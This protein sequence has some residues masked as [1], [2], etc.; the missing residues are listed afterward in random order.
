MENSKFEN[1]QPVNLDGILKEMKNI[2]E[3]WKSG[4]G[5]G[6][7]EELEVANKLAS[8]DIPEDRREEVTKIAKEF[9]IEADN[10]EVIDL[11]KKWLGLPVDKK[12]DLPL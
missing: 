9:M 7:Q 10:Q 1:I 2:T 5:D 6:Q 12:E 3:K 8:L 11:V 4:K